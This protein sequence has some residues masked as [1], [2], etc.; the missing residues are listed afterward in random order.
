MSGR[1]TRRWRHDGSL[2]P[3]V[4]LG[5]SPSDSMRGEVKLSLAVNPNAGPERD[6]ATTCWFDRWPG[7]LETE[8]FIPG[9]AISWKRRTSDRAHAEDRPVESLRPD[10]IPAA[11][12][13]LR[14]HSIATHAV[15]RRLFPSF[16]VVASR[17]LTSARSLVSRVI[18]RG[19]CGGSANLPAP[20]KTQGRSQSSGLPRCR[21][22]AASSASV[23]WPPSCS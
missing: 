17:P 18:D 4:S 1:R 19:W 15:A 12:V 5:G 21:S 3:T 14:F 2:G 22:C 20:T 11:P 6:P 8:G 13:S 9:P 7:R 16:F 10:K 23:Y